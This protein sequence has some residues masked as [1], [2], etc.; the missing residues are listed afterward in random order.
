MIIKFQFR[1]YYMKCQIPT[2]TKIRA[3]GNDPTAPVLA[4]PVFLKVKITS[5]FTKSNYSN[6]EKC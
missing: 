3:G 1:L 2:V 6:N 5:I 4:G